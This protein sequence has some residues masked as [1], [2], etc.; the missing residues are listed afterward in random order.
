METEAKAKV[1]ASVWGGG[2]GKIYPIPCCA[3]YF[4]YYDL[5]EKVEFI[6]FFQIEQGKAASVARN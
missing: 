1:V 2:C 5:E 3:S 4:A 6:L